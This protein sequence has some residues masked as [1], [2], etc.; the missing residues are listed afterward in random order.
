MKAV[1]VSGGRAPS[2]ELIKNELIN[3]SLL[4]CGD[5]GANCL[6]EYKIEPNYLI[7]D[8]D[9]VNPNVLEYFKTKDCIIEKYPRDKDF[10]DT[11]LCMKKAILSGADEI[12]FLG[13][14]GTRIDH[15]LGNIG[16]LLKCLKNDVRAYIKDDNNTI[17]ITNKSIVLNKT[18]AKYFSVYAYSEVVK[19]LSIKNAKFPLSN[20]N[21]S[22]GDPLTISNEFIDDDIII[23]FKSGF[24]LI[25][26]CND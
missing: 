14:T 6:K 11:Y 3:S 21:L 25:M 18:H 10:T 26:I 13:C 24:L 2:V 19:C 5:S 15:I 1:I 22:I 17:F 23:E 12:A 7:G 9:S 16:V 4:I 8:F 20:Y